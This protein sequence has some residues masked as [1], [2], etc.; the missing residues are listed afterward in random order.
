MTAQ[1][2]LAKMWGNQS[3]FAAGFSDD[4]FDL[5]LGR[6]PLNGIDYGVTVKGHYTNDSLDD[7]R[8]QVKEWS[9]GAFLHY[10]VL[11]LEGLD[12]P[13]QGR[14]LATADVVTD[15]SQFGE[16]W[17]VIPGIQGEVV[18]DRNINSEDIITSEVLGLLG[19]QYA[20]S[21]GEF[22]DEHWFG[23]GIV[24]RWKD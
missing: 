15:S 13:V 11:N 20:I 14:V 21:P 19:Y 9:V 8:L 3:Y 23:A 12:I 7:A 1:A 18:I 2:D 5:K 17:F 22:E 4:L 6:T 10:P 24:V 16:D